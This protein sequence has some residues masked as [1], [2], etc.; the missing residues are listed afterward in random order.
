MYL[1]DVDSN[2]MVFVCGIEAPQ[3]YIMHSV[4]HMH[5]RK[6]TMEVKYLNNELS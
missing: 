2:V 3:Y 4:P 6:T 5:K 1:H